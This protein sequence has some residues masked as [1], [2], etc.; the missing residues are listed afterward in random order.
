LIADDFYRG[1]PLK[2]IQENNEAEIMQVV[3]DE[4]MSSYPPEIVVELTSEGIDDLEANVSRILE[5]IKNW[6]V[7]R[8]SGS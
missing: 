4:A 8:E 6:Q 2:K 7:E 1:Y 3:L 5:W